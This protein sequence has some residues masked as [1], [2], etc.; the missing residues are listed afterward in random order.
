MS[1]RNTFTC[2]NCEGA[3]DAKSLPDDWDWV[4]VSAMRT[5]YRHSLHLCSTCIGAMRQSRARVLIG[6]IIDMT[7]RKAMRV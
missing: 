3:V 1:E 7:K 2:D 4:H 6:R 5:G